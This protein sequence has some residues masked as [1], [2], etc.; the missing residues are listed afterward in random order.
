MEAVLLYLLLG[1]SIGFI[2]AVVG[3]GG[4]LIAIPLLVL[5]F[6]M[7]QQLA[8]G[9]ALIM[10]VSN[11]LIAVRS[12]NKT[13]KIDFKSVGIA[14]L[15]NMMATNLA[16]MLAQ[17]VDPVLLRRL[18]AVFLALI[19]S[20]YVWQTL[21]RKTKSQ[22]KP[23]TASAS[24]LKIS[25]SVFLGLGSGFIGGLFGVG[26]SLI[27]VPVLTMYYGFRQ[28]TAQGVALSMI[29][30]GSGVALATYAWNGNADWLIGVCMGIGGMFVVK[31]GV[32]LA[33]RL[34]E[35]HLK[36]IFSLVLFFT[37]ALLLTK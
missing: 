9:T 20:L 16:A 37:V 25:T 13:S 11:V 8:Q 6:D 5:L 29:V 10:I 7:P 2:G 32:K 17:G 3:I 33:Y 19:A 35:V 28:T 31:Y 23:E 4:G 34:P 27:V 26:G 24:T 36:R 14:V 30:P 22:K 15:V 12:Y 21:P 18:F 1:A